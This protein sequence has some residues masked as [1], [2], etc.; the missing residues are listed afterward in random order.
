[1]MGESIKQRAGRRLGIPLED[2]GMSR[3]I[4][5]VAALRAAG[6]AL[7]AAA[8]PPP[9]WAQAAPRSIAIGL[10]SKTASDWSVY[11][12]DKMGFFDKNGLKPD[13]I[14]TGS[15]AANAQQLTAGSVDIGEISTT[16]IIEAIL[17]G[18]PIV[19]FLNRSNNAPYLIIGKKGLSSISQLRG[20]TIIV[21]G[22]NDITLVFMNTILAAYKMTPD[23]V[24]YTF[25]GGTGERFAALLSGTV[26]AAILLPPFS[27]RA[28]SAGYPVLDRVQKYFPVFPFDTFSVRT[29]FAKKNP[30][31]ITAYAKSI[32]QGVAWLYNPANRSKA[33]S[34]LADESNV[35]ADDS[36]KTYDFFIT[37][38]QYYNRTGVMTNSDLAPVITALLKTGQL[39]PPAPDPAR[40]YDNSFVIKANAELKRR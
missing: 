26:D 15:S 28:T 16:Q 37:Q 23:D 10:T 24:T 5:R 27:F 35:S 36:A 1:M 22:P 39:K 11:V 6:A 14:I 29:D 20:K 4:S 40:F 25:A 17:G 9:A 33:I 8:I 7:A 19:S 38:A 13:V 12:A 21:G 32:L 34:I 2:A 3:L 30:D 18:A 31:M